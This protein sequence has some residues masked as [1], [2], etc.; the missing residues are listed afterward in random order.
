MGV[1]CGLGEQS[2]NW[3]LYFVQTS[4]VSIDAFSCKL[5][6]CLS[7]LSRL[8]R[9]ACREGI[10]AYW[11]SISIQQQRAGSVFHITACFNCAAI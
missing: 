5:W 11:A 2:P 9:Q 7:P 1:S 6:A 10:L 4:H 3:V 8:Q